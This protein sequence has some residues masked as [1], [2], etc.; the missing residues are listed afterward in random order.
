MVHYVSQGHAFETV[1]AFLCDKRGRFDLRVSCRQLVKSR[2]HISDCD[3]L[4]SAH[5][6]R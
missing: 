2:L 1:L 5:G 4:G 6:V 3:E